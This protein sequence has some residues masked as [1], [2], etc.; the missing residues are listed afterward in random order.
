MGSRLPAHSN[1]KS[2]AP[3]NAREIRREPTLE[4]PHRNIH[5]LL[6]YTKR[7]HMLH[8]C[9]SENVVAVHPNLAPLATGLSGTARITLPSSR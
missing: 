4:F 2:L 9:G 6:R 7:N 8:R 5:H 3:M 1:N